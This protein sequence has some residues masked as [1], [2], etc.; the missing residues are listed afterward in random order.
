[1]HLPPGGGPLAICCRDCRKIQLTHARQHRNHIVPVPC[2]RP[3]TSSEKA[4]ARGAPRRP[5]AFRLL[6]LV[7]VQAERGESSKLAQLVDLDPVRMRIGRPQG[8][9]QRRYTRAEASTCLML[10]T[11]L[12]WR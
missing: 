1:M 10:S 9:W 6:N 3:R 7:A 8:P 2:R 4:H 5:L 11:L 12:P